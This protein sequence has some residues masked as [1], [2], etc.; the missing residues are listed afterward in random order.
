VAYGGETRYTKKKKKVRR[1]EERRGVR[2]S[3]NG[4]QRKRLFSCFARASRAVNDLSDMTVLVLDS[5]SQSIPLGTNCHI[6]Q[7]IKLKELHSVPVAILIKLDKS[8]QQQY[9]H[10]LISDTFVEW[11]TS[12]SN[13]LCWFITSF[14]IYSSCIYY[15]Y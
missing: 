10:C 8:M 4:S 6:N 3:S 13:L 5:F 11:M 2:F 9:W 7:N 14:V 12:L 1:E 15:I